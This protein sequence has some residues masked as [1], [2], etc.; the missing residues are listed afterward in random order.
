ME[1]NLVTSEISV[2][3]LIFSK[4]SNLQLLDSEVF[5]FY[6]PLWQAR[7]LGTSHITRRCSVP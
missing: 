5:I 7:L 3:S 4:S 1:I 2:Q 6:S